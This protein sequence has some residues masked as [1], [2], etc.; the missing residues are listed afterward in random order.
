MN[1]RV[2]YSLSL[3]FLLLSSACIFA[4]GFFIPEEAQTGRI[5]VA[6]LFYTFAVLGYLMFFITNKKRK[7]VYKEKTSKDSGLIKLL[8]FFSNKYAAVADV[9]FLIC[10]AGTIAVIV[11]AEKANFFHFFVISLFFFSANAHF[12]LNGE[13]FKYI[14]NV[15][16]IKGRIKK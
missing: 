14:F 13:N 6:V 5:T 7:S 9:V 3:V 2:T 12:M 16:N 15:T 1:L 8:R 11:T 4:M 10:L